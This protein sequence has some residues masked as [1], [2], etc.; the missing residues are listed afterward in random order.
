MLVEDKWQGDFDRLSSSWKDL[1]HRLNEEPQT[2]YRRVWRENV[3][4][5]I[6]DS[7]EIDIELAQVCVPFRLDQLPSLQAPYPE[8]IPVLLRHL[9]RKHRRDIEAAII[10]ALA[11]PYAGEEAVQILTEL[12]QSRRE[13]M[14]PTTLYALG[15]ALAEI[16]GKGGAI[17]LRQIA[18]DPQ[19]G[20]ARLEPMLKLG[21]IKDP[22]VESIALSW[23]HA[24][25]LPWYAIRALRKAKVW[26]AI[27][28]VKDFLDAED[29]EIRAEARKFCK[30]AADKT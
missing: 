2:E 28:T 30:V 17:L 21:Q 1:E 8:A 9:K 20:D 14:P 11:I 29:S 16:A 19:N 10:S 7:Q 23:L 6:A 3:L 5:N 27:E 24:N 13:T 22:G 12:L 18:S 26:T 15:N 4:A 25:E